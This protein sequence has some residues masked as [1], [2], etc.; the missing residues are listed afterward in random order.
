MYLLAPGAEKSGKC[1]ECSS[2]KLDTLRPFGGVYP[3]RSR[4]AVSA[5]TEVST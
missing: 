4:R 3:E 1:K 2:T 5:K